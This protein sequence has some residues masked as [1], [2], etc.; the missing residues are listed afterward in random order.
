MVARAF[1][2]PRISRTPLESCAVCANGLRTAHARQMRGH[3]RN[4]R[5]PEKQEKEGCAVRAGDGLKYRA[6]ADA[7][8]PDATA[9]NSRADPLR[10]HAREA[11]P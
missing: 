7:R 1:S 6:F 11:R 3:A 8:I 10:A 4:A 9:R 2:A 5:R